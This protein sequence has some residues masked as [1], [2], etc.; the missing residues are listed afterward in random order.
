M[1]NR[2]RSRT[3]NP[4]VE[5]GYTAQLLAARNQNVQDDGDD[6]FSDVDY[7][8]STSENVYRPDET[9]VGFGDGAFDYSAK[10]HMLDSRLLGKCRMGAIKEAIIKDCDLWIVCST[11]TAFVGIAALGNTTAEMDTWCGVVMSYWFVVSML[12]SSLLSVT[13]VMDNICLTSYYNMVPARYILKARAHKNHQMKKLRKDHT[14]FNCI[15]IFFKTFGIKNFEYNMF[16]TSL[17]VLLFGTI[18]TIFLMYKQEATQK[19]MVSDV[20][21]D[22]F[23]IA[24][25]YCGFAAEYLNLCSPFIPMSTIVI[26]VVVIAVVKKFSERALKSWF[27]I[28]FIFMIVIIDSNIFSHLC[29]ELNLPPSLVTLLL[30]VFSLIIGFIDYIRVTM[31]CWWGDDGD[32]GNNS[33]K[34][35]SVLKSFTDE[36]IKY[37][38]LTYCEECRQRHHHQRH[39]GE[40]ENRRRGPSPVV[41][42]SSDCT[43]SHHRRHANNNH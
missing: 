42:T 12:T 18:P 8:E 27:L 16:R 7:I 3:R 11:L 41:C 38:D 31:K 36:C 20:F 5:L 30:I 6:S 21:S 25:D 35:A 22:G 37:K 23:K 19:K 26:I 34:T 13:S 39:R 10:L 43:S 2:A 29:A 4:I 28:I 32:D 17:E 15:I 40:A 24:A 9:D 33:D 1:P 14:F